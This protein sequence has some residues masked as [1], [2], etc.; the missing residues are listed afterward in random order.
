MFD[1]IYSFFRFAAFN[2]REC[3]PRKKNVLKSPCIAVSLLP[4]SGEYIHVLVFYFWLFVCLFMQQEN[5]AN[6]PVTVVHGSQVNVPLS[7]QHSPP[8]QL[9]V[10]SPPTQEDL[11]HLPGRLRESNPDIPR[12]GFHCL[13]QSRHRRHLSQW[14]F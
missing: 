14:G 1:L 13:Q 3:F 9:P 8:T 6:S 4:L 7:V 11:W 10:V 12:G 2:L 5:G